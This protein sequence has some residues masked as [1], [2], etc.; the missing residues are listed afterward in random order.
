M[1]G[2]ILNPLLAAKCKTLQQHLSNA[3]L[4][5]GR[6]KPRARCASH[7][8]LGL[9]VPDAAQTH[10]TKHAQKQLLRRQTARLNKM[11][12]RRDQQH[13]T[14][15][16]VTSTATNRCIFCFSGS[17]GPFIAAAVGTHNTCTSWLVKWHQGGVGEG[18]EAQEAPLPFGRRTTMVAVVIDGAL[19]KLQ[20]MCSRSSTGVPVY[21]YA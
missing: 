7:G 13:H 17:R 6:S 14:P 4:R 8:R 18:R 9:A 3:R 15:G 19:Q 11:K 12:S 5:E 16:S 1:L 20:G 21:Q 2:V 10:R